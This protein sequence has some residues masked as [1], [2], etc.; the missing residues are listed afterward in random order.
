MGYQLSLSFLAGM[1]LAVGWAL[2]ANRSRMARHTGIPQGGP[3]GDVSKN[4]V[5]RMERDM[6]RDGPNH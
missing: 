2:R 4:A 5:H 1:V 6:A 3:N